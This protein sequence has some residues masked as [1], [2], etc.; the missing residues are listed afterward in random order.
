VYRLD[1]IIDSAFVRIHILCSYYPSLHHSCK[2][3]NERSDWLLPEFVIVGRIIHVMDVGSGKG[4]VSFAH[5]PRSGT[6]TWK[7]L[8]TTHALD[9]HLWAPQLH[10]LPY[11][12]VYTK[13]RWYVTL[14]DK[15]KNVGSLQSVI[16]ADSGI[17]ALLFYSR[18]IWILL[19]FGWTGNLSF[20]QR[21]ILPWLSSLC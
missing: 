20:R 16:F 9:L 2:C 1:K 4:M 6:K 14:Y 11:L 7:R 21:M 5:I 17:R 10:L 12:H 13:G 19:E 15:Q 18:R 8:W 3:R